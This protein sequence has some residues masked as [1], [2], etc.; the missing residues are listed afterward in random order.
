MN[1]SLDRGS[2]SGGGAVSG[3]EG[4]DEGDV[5]AATGRGAPPFLPGAGPSG[6][7]AGPVGAFAAGGA[8]TAGGGSSTG[9]AALAS[10]SGAGTGAG[11]G[12]GAGT[13]AAGAPESAALEGSS[14]AAF[15]PDRMTRT[16][17]PTETAIAA[18]MP[19]K[20]F[21]PPPLFV[22][23]GEVLPTACE[24]A[25]TADAPPPGAGPV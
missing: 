9:A 10:V 25:A 17:A 6:R 8:D 24:V 23:P 1:R 4:V 14:A 11:D 22:G 5:E 20:A 19:A 3:L 18:A 15:V 16:V 2:E 7:E 13:I 21:V 12:G